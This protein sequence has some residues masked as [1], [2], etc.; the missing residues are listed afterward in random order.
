MKLPVRIVLAAGAFA[1]A[2]ALV[3]GV[4]HCLRLMAG[5]RALREPSAPPVGHDQDREAE[6]LAA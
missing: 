1:A 6:L 3:T 5:R 4:R 2:I